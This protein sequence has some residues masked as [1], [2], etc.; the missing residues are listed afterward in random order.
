MNFIK[1]MEQE[2]KK[3]SIKHLFKVYPPDMDSRS[4]GDRMWNWITK[5][6]TPALLEKIEL[7]NPYLEEYDAF[8]WD[9]YNNAMK[10]LARLVN[11]IQEDNNTLQVTEKDKPIQ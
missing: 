11:S 6:Y 10:D 2:F 9:A 1:T 7:E 4:M 5:V 8:H 3:S